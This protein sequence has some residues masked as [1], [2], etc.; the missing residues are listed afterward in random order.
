V[1]WGFW[2]AIPF[3]SYSLVT[4]FI[5]RCSS[6]L[7]RLHIQKITYKRKR[8]YIELRPD[9]GALLQ[10]VV[11]FHMESYDGCKQLWKNC[12]EYHAFFR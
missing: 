9:Q 1:K 8:F 4:V 6:L 5:T 12:I 11:G 3:S 10:N 7:R 2:L